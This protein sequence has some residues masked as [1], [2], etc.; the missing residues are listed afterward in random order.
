[1][2]FMI[3]TSKLIGII[4]V[5]LTGFDLFIL[6]YSDSLTNPDQVFVSL[7]NYP[8]SSYLSRSINQYSFNDVGDT[9]HQQTRPI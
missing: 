2:A 5:E 8:S 4:K 7:Y 3:S 6:K 9:R 1:M